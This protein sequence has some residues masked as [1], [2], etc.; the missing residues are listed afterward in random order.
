MYFHYATLSRR[1]AKHQSVL[2]LYTT[3]ELSRMEAT[4]LAKLIQDLREEVGN[5][6]LGDIHVFCS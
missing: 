1:Y 6:A 2:A 4:S 5:I 3:E